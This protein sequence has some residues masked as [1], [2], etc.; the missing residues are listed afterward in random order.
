M[1]TP[2]IFPSESES[3]DLVGNWQ[4]GYLLLGLK[5]SKAEMIKTGS[6]GSSCL[7]KISDQLE[8]QGIPRSQIDLPPVWRRLSLVL[9]LRV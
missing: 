5:S 9:N 4:V 6:P 2:D 7:R 8:L 1:R 3:E